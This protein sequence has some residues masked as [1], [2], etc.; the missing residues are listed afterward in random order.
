[1]PRIQA[2]VVPAN[3]DVI[4]DEFDLS[5]IS[6]ADVVFAICSVVGAFILAWITK[7]ALRRMFHSIDGMPVL[8]GDVI[9]RMVGYGIVTLGIVLAFEA[10]GFSLGPV[11][12]LLLVVIVLVILAARPLLQDLGAGLIIQVRRP[13]SVGDQLAVEDALGQVQEVNARTVVVLSVDGKRI[14]LPN[15]MVLEDAIFNLTSEGQRMTTFVAGVAYSTD[16]DEARSVIVEAMAG[17]AA[18]LNDPA[19]AA[20]VEEFSDS[21]INIACR[22]WH[23]PTVQEEWMAR[24]QA[25]RAVKRAFDAHGITIAFPQRVLWSAPN[26]A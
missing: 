9:A 1:M 17:E 10:L 26:A 8:A 2:Q 21:T 13:F 19:P 18:V 11:G 24:D 5:T 15:R 4:T 16:L 23:A 14:H 3:I 20:F 25:M 7:R 12:A 6:T 22:F